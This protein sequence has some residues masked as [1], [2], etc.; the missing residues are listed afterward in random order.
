MYEGTC[1]CY[2]GQAV[3]MVDLLHKEHADIDVNWYCSCLWEHLLR[4]QHRLFHPHQQRQCL[5]P[6]QPALHMLTCSVLVRRHTIIVTDETFFLATLNV[7]L[8][9]ISQFVHPLYMFSN[10]FTECT[11]N[12]YIFFVSCFCLP[13]YLSEKSVTSEPCVILTFDYLWNMHFYVCVSNHSLAIQL[14][15]TRHCMCIDVWQTYL[16]RHIKQTRILSPTSCPP[17][18][19]RHQQPRHRH[20]HH[21]SVLRC[22]V[23]RRRQPLPQAVLARRMLS[24][25]CMVIHRQL[26]L[27][28]TPCR[29]PVCIT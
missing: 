25:L 11:Y 15:L 22:L 12:L 3:S 17:V 26:L 18:S 24:W 10:F 7:S 2:C 9:S 20:N 21:M 27:D 1:V 23:R 14:C 16:R 29:Q 5:T 19:P 6:S 8:P 4:R 28:R 13:V